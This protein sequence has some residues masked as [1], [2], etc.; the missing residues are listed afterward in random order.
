MSNKKPTRDGQNR[1]RFPHGKVHDL[2]IQLTM[3]PGAQRLVPAG[4]VGRVLQF[5][6]DILMERGKVPRPGQSFECG[7][8][9]N[10]HDIVFAVDNHGDGCPHVFLAVPRELEFVKGEM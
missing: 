3:T 7:F 1:T 9:A 5:G 4:Q 6:F 2:P 8:E 10:G